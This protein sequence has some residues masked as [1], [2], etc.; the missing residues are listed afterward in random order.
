MTKNSVYTIPYSYVKVYKGQTCHPL[1]VRLEEHRKVVCRGEIEKLY[2][3]DHKLKE[4]GNP[5]PLWDEVR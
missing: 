4:K 5:L 1:Q 2:M 3:A